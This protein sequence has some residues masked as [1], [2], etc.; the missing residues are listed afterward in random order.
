MPE[1]PFLTGKHNIFSGIG[2]TLTATSLGLQGKD[3]SDVFRD[4]DEIPDY[5][6]ALSQAQLAQFID[7]TGVQSAGIA[8]QALGGNRLKSQTVK[9]PFGTA[10]I[11]NVE[12][13]TVE[14]T[15]EGLKKAAT[16]KTE[17]SQKAKGQLANTK[18]FIKNFIESKT[19]LETKFPNLGESNLKGFAQRIAAFATEKTGALP[20]TTAFINN[21]EVVANQQARDI[22]GGRVTDKDRS[23]YAKAMANAIKFPTQTNIIAVSN[24]LI[25]MKNKEANLSPILEEFKSSGVPF[26]KDVAKRVEDSDKPIKSEDFKKTKSGVKYRILE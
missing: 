13:P 9:T 7:P 20:A 6:L 14:G 1:K 18:S 4:L 16:E 3:P 26:L 8:N 10:T 25:Q 2:R 19:E 12:D 11:E 21:S 22:E 24:A 15:R 5:N 17:I 23:V